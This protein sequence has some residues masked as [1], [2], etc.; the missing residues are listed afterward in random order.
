MANT[1]QYASASAV[2]IA[3]QVGRQARAVVA[4]GA[5]GKKSII[6]GYIVT[7]A[8]TSGGTLSRVVDPPA[9]ITQIGWTQPSGLT[10]LAFGYTQVVGNRDLY[11]PGA[12]QSIPPVAPPGVVPVTGSYKYVS[13][14]PAD[15]TAPLLFARSSAAWV[16]TN[17]IYAAGPLR[18]NTPGTG[19]IG[20]SLI[21]VVGLSWGAS[22]VA[23][24]DYT[25]LVQLAPDSPVTTKV[26]Y[27]HARSIAAAAGFSSI[28]V[29]QFISD[30][31][32][33]SAYSAAGVTYVAIHARDTTA[34]LPEVD[35]PLLLVGAIGASDEAEVPLLWS[36][37]LRVG[38]TTTSPTNVYV[39][40]MA[41]LYVGE[42]E[43]T[44]TS[45]VWDNTGWFS[46]KRHV[47]DK[48]TGATVSYASVSDSDVVVYAPVASTEHGLWV[49]KAER[50]AGA[51]YVDKPNTVEL[52][53]GTTTTPVSLAGWSLLST[54]IPGLDW[55]GLLGPNTSPPSGAVARLGDGVLGVVACPAP[56]SPTGYDYDA[57]IPVHL[58]EVDEATM[59]FVADR[60]FIA[61]AQIGA[62]NQTLYRGFNVTTVTQQKVDGDGNVAVPA[63]LLANYASTTRISND[64]GATW[65]V[66]ATGVSGF[67]YYRGNRLHPFAV[68]E[69][70]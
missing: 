55:N 54:L 17:V 19:E 27:V 61:N 12:D 13:P 48:T 67:P 66:I 41:G 44:L 70:L 36:R 58:I 33:P 56:S 14:A 10:E 29:S 65:R 68:G 4:S 7:T 47:L 28:T 43:V 64:G 69:Q 16:D 22:M 21:H 40:D 24:A 3:G 11:L 38:A 5:G 42:T 20:D 15:P 30:V 63:V 62:F 1:V 46:T 9:L 37:A 59:A 31:F 39:P 52:W 57:P 35:K 53:N 2:T 23:A 32:R 45:T 18:V 51:S 60:G 8:R 25:S 6:D 49:V 50:T 34:G 26:L